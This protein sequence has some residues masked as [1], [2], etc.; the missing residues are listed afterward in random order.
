MIGYVAASIPV[1]C[2]TGDTLPH[3]SHVFAFPVD[4]LAIFASM[5][6]IIVKASLGFETIQNIR[7]GDRHK[8]AVANQTP[9]K[10][11]N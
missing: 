10:G 1:S 8:L 4:A 9:D 2:N 6:N 5:E 11:V 7:L 3:M